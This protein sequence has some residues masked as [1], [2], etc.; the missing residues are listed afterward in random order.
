MNMTPFRTRNT[1]P[2]KILRDVTSY[3]IRHSREMENVLKNLKKS[4]EDSRMSMEEIVDGVL[5]SERVLDTI[6]N[7]CETR[8]R[9]EE[10][11]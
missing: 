8:R 10:K 1:E 4:I 2:A 5:A 9:K 3:L 7:Y 6:Y 11:Q